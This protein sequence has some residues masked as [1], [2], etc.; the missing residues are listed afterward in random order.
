MDVF[1][2]RASDAA[3]RLKTSSSS[4]QAS[5]ATLMLGAPVY[6]EPTMTFVLFLLPP[7]SC[8]YWLTFTTGVTTYTLDQYIFSVWD[9]SLQS[10]A[11]PFVEDV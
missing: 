7:L 4:L 6:Y 8:L 5:K 9:M 2:N 3:V 10:N 1:K 11:V